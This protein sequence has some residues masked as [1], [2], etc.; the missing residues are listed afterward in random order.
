M[1]TKI[2]KESLLITKEKAGRKSAPHCHQ[3]GW[4]V[5]TNCQLLSPGWVMIGFGV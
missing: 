1:N 4:L 5:P 3:V 2:P